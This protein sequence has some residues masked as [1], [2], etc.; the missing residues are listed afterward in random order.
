MVKKALQIWQDPEV[1]EIGR[2]PMSCT[3]RRFPNRRSALK[4]GATNHEHSINGSWKFLWVKTPDQVPDQFYSR[5]VNDQ[6]WDVIQVPG[7]WQ[8]QGYGNPHYHNIGLPPGADE[9]NPPKI[10]PDYNN[11]GCYRKKFKLPDKWIEKRIFLHFGG[12]KAAF[13]VWLNG[14]NLGY[15]Q[16]SMLPAEF[17]VSNLIVPGE[18]QLAVLVYRFC[19]GSFLEDQDMW[20]LNGIFRDVYFYCAPRILIDDFY[21]RCSFDENFQEATFLADVKLDSTIEDK[22]QYRLVLEML[23][24]DGKKVFKQIKDFSLAGGLKYEA[25][26]QEL[27]PNPQKWSAETPLLYTVVISLLDNNKKVLEVIPSNFGFR[28][29]EIINRQVLLNGK[30]ILIKGVNRHEFDPVSGYTVSPENMEAQVKMLKQYN[31]NAVRTSHYPNHPYFY[32]LCD[33]FGLYVMDEANV[34][35]HAYVKHLPRGKSEWREAVVSRAKRMVLRDRNHPS[36]IFWSL[37]NEAGSGKNFQYMREAILELDQTR[38]IH[39]EGEHK[40]PNSDLIS[41]MYPSPEFL[42]KLAQGR[43]P[44]RFSKAGE[45][46]GKWIWP[47]NYNS[48]PILICEYAHAMGNSISSLHK[49]REI[50]ESYTHCAGG[51]IWDMI[52]QSL[53]QEKED[54]SMVWTYGGDWGDQPND[55]YF[56]IN[57]LFQP[58]LKPN[59]HAHEVKKVFQ[60]ISASPGDLLQG[61]IILKNKH[62]FLDLSFTYLKWS[63]TRN[64]VEENSGEIPAP[65]LGPGEEQ[66]ILLP[67]SI[68]EESRPGDEYHLTL[69]FHLAQDTSWGQAGFKIAWEQFSLPVITEENGKSVVSGIL[70]TPLLIHPR[71]DQL[72]VLH[73][74]ITVSFNTKTGFMESIS[75]GETQ[76][77]E[78]PLQPNFLRRLDNDVIMESWFPRLGRWLSSYRKW[79][80]AQN[81]IELVEFTTDRL[82]SGGVRIS[83]IYKIPSGQTHLKISTVIHPQGTVQISSTFKPGIEMLR[84]GLQ[85]K[86]SGSLTEI[87]W[88]GRGPHETMPDRK[89]SGLI[90][91]HTA[92]SSSI[93]YDYIHPQ[94]NGNRSDTRWVIFQ[95]QDGTGYKI[96]AMDGRF[97]NFSL[98]P[99]SQDDLLRAQHI[100]ELPTRDYF[101]LNIDLTQRGVGDLMSPIYGFDEDTRLRKGKTYNFEFKLSPVI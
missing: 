41:L 62:S 52:D 58:D 32:E 57:G 44:L 92:K 30:P 45:T 24:P 42:E 55:G 21:L 48:K 96:E 60:A 39:Y 80:Q 33:R 64:G 93:R 43:R 85:G 1:F 8:L 2:K 38:P 68:P 79:D 61:E 81:D 89:Q 63:L 82:D 5:N 99:Y 67:V 13:Q 59:P 4:N 86:I 22:K 18:N 49:F 51:Y 29:I 100:Q 50:F 7:L 10:N 23:D 40:S 73:P 34:E 53:L 70:T 19:D 101:T 37:G 26:F 87:S 15:S 14:I 47:R 27:L 17:E 31:I 9:K 12:V 72:T 56:C 77:L 76:F 95:E 88:F 74:L 28:V 36:V 46:I 54:G 71:E 98:W 75:T 66:P 20:Y 16:D 25:E 83:S 6:D 94:E 78:G 3:S 91:I 65:A 90:K 69:S 11:L 35:S 97:F 84:F